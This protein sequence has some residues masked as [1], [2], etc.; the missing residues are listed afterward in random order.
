MYSKEL[1]WFQEFSWPD[2][3]GPSLKRLINAEYNYYFIFVYMEKKLFLSVA[4]V[5][6]SGHCLSPNLLP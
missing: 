1:R 2:D 5:G 4:T 3:Q 6:S